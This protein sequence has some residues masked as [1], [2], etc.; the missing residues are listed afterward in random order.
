MALEGRALKFMRRCTKNGVPIY[1]LGFTMLFSMLSFLQLSNSGT[2]V[3]NWLINLVTSGIMINFIIICITYL[4]F[5]HACKAQGLDRKT[6][7]YRGWFQPYAAWIGLIVL[8]IL[9]L[10]QGYSIFLLGSFTADGFL[11]IYLMIILAPFTYLGWK[12]FARTKLVK[13]EELDL[14]WLAPEIDDYEAGL[15]EEPK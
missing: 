1:C 15:P 13:T 14:V 4:R 9:A 3:L 10:I 11:T 7:L 2:T 8:V 12:T 6:L 5:Y